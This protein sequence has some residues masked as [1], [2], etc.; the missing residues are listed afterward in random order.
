MGGVAAI[1]V[2]RKL[3]C[4]VALECY[5]LVLCVGALVAC[6]SVPH[7]FANLLQV[8]QGGLQ[9]VGLFLLAAVTHTGTLVQVVLALGGVAALLLLRD[10]A[11]AALAPLRLA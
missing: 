3:V 9:Q 7:V 4:R 8:E 5:A 10:S 11:R 1:Y 6:V 2:A